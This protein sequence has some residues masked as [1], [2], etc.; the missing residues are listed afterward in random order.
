MGGRINSWHYLYLPSLQLARHSNWLSENLNWCWSKDETLRRCWWGW[1]C[2][3]KRMFKSYFSS[4]THEHWGKLGTEERSWAR[5]WLMITTKGETSWDIIIP[6]DIW[7]RCW[8]RG[9]E[10]CLGYMEKVG[11]RGIRGARGSKIWER[12]WGGGWNTIYEEH[13]FFRKG[14]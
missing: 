13:E 2:S 9:R 3:S 5:V 11:I 12:Q 8:W 4:P 10:G 14:N 6:V 1:L 7:G